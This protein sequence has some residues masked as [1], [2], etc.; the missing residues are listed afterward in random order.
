MAVRPITPLLVAFALILGSCTTTQPLVQHDDDV[1][2]MPSTAKAASNAQEPEPSA[3]KP[4]AEEPANDD[5]YDPDA[6]AASGAQRGY[7]D[8]AYNDPHYYNYGRFGFG[9]GMGWQ[10]GWNGPGWGMGMG[11]GNGGMGMNNGWNDPWNQPWGMNNPWGGFG[12]WNYGGNM[13]WYNGGYGGWGYPGYGGWGTGG[14]NGWGYGGYTGWGWGNWDYGYGSY[15]GPYGP[16]RTCYVPVVIG[17]S[18]NTYVGHRPPSNRSSNT[19]SSGS[20]PRMARDPIG[21]APN[22]PLSEPSRSIGEQSRPGLRPAQPLTEPIRV[23]EPRPVERPMERKPSVGPNRERQ[24]GIER[25]N[26]RTFERS[27]PSPAPSR[28]G[29]GGSSPTRHRS[30]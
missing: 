24:P 1:Y 30:R 15:W 28:D 3:S 16:C 6:A 11:W 13:N 19:G 25:P 4:E 29:G 14:Y 8:M 27:S 18:S 10:S 20:F 26:E 22:K 2:F 23:R 17:G 21:L 12:G 7:Y 5:Y 9:S